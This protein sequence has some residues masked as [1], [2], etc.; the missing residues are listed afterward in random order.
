MNA[1]LG[2]A[3]SC[4]YVGALVIVLQSGE[5]RGTAGGIFQATL[6]LCNAIGP[7][8]GGLIAQ[9]WGYRGVMFFAAGLGVAGMFTA[10]PEAGKTGDVDAGAKN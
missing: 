8:L 7:L 1:L 4:L 2:V 5:E 6:N 9:Y 3:W 10:L